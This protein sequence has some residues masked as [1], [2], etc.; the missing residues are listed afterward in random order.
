MTAIHY[1]FPSY[2]SRAISPDAAALSRRTSELG[3]RCRLELSEVLDNLECD[4]AEFPRISPLLA[5]ACIVRS[6]LT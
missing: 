2:V 3:V 5:A 6:S 1:R 4:A